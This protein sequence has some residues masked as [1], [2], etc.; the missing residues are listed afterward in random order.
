MR[1]KLLQLSSDS[2]SRLPQA[3]DF[4]VYSGKD[5]ITIAVTVEA[6]DGLPTVVFVPLQKSCIPNLISALTDALNREREQTGEC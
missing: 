3:S 6:D 2:T 4:E 5:T 1:S